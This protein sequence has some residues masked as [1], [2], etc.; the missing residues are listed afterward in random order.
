[1]CNLYYSDICR[2][3]DETIEWMQNFRSYGK[4]LFVF[5][6]KYWYIFKMYYELKLKG[7]SHIVSL[8][9]YFVF[10]VNNSTDCSTGNRKSNAKIVDW[11]PLNSNKYINYLLCTMQELFARS[12][13]N[14]S[15]SLTQKL[16]SENSL[17]S[18]AKLAA[19]FTCGH[20]RSSVSHAVLLTFAC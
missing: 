2:S 5:H 13:L 6:I 1:M 14:K 4:S 20:W 3:C 11:A 10:C 12:S 19:L 16:I 9:K 7:Q 8:W 15:D 17:F 18:R